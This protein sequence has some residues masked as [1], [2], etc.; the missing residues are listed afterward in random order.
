VKT[1]LAVDGEPTNLHL[2]QNCRR[3]HR[4]PPPQLPAPPSASKIELARVG[5]YPVIALPRPG[6]RIDAA[7]VMAFTSAFLWIGYATLRG[8]VEAS[9]AGAEHYWLGWVI[10]SWLLLIGASGVLQ[11]ITLML[12]REYVRDDGSILTLGKRILGIG[13]GRSSIAK[14]TV[15]DV[16]IGPAE[17][18][19]G[20]HVRLQEAMRQKLPSLGS[21]QPPG[22][23]LTKERRQECGGTLST[24]E[25]QW[26]VEALR[27]ICES[28]A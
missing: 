12:A 19:E 11:G 13:Y 9:R 21:W 4:S 26:L 22:A 10:G 15:M 3:R 6:F 5:V 16:T 8:M 23:I 27:L 7:L 28:R 24:A 25:Q 2:I 17:S 18:A 20:E 1:R 14:D